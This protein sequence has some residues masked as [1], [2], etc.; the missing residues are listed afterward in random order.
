MVHPWF[1]SVEKARIDFGGYLNARCG[2][3]AL[4]VDRGSFR[5]DHFEPMVAGRPA[6]ALRAL[7]R[8]LLV[9]T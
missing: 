1:V 8:K 2:A 6:N 7:E 4:E 3:A 5:L 9:H